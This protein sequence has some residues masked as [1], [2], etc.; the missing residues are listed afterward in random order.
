MFWDEICLLECLIL[1]RR[2]EQRCARLFRSMAHRLPAE[3]AATARLLLTLAA[4]EERHDQ[5]LEL[6]EKAAPMP[7]TWRMDERALEWALGWLF[8][9]LS[10]GGEQG[11]LDANE[12]LARVR[13][14]E[15][16]SVRFYQGLRNRTSDPET[17][18]ALETILEQ[19]A[20]HIRATS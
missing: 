18:Q 10:E 5:T 14:I 3:Q 8:P 20:A 17:L 19:E 16:E 2:A 11:A 7:V 1:A 4:E 15:R 12:A 9:S 6:L 13:K